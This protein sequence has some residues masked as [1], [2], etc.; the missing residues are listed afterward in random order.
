MALSPIQQKQRKKGGKGGLFGKIAGSVVGGVVGSFAGAPL[1]GA[2]AGGA[3]GGAIGGAVDPGEVTGGRSTPL[4]SVANDPEVRIGQMLE[5]QKELTKATQL[6]A[7][8]V[9]D[10]NASIQK[11]IDMERKRFA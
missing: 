3:L 1:Q 2:A 10:I 5:A 8:Q 6:S 7:P 9:E 4:S 11:A